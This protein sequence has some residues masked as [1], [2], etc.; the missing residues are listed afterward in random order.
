MSIFL[1]SDKEKKQKEAH[2]S[3]I[4]ELLKNKWQR[5]WI[6]FTSRFKVLLKLD[7]SIESIRKRFS[8]NCRCT[9]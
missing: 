1:I 5:P 6:P 4:I 2:K 3:N 7:N 9:N 8:R